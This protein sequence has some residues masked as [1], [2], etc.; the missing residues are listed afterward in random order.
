M[1]DAWA[2]RLQEIYSSTGQLKIDSALVPATVAVTFSSTPIFDA[3]K[4]NAFQ[5]TLTGDV[6]SSTLSNATAGQFIF[7]TITQD[8]TGGHTFA[9]PSNF[10]NAPTVVSTA[11]KATNVVGFYDGTNFNIAGQWN[12][13][14]SGT[15]GGS[16]TSVGMTGD[17][18]LYQPTVSGSPITTSGTLAPALASADAGYVL[19]GPIGSM[20]SNVSYRQSKVAVAS[21]T[22]GTI[23]FDSPI[24]SGSAIVVVPLATSSGG[25]YFTTISDTL[26]TSYTG[27]GGAAAT[28][29][30][31]GFAA[32]SGT[33]TIT[34]SGG[35]TASGVPILA[36][37]LP[38]AA[39]YVDGS[40]WASSSWNTGGAAPFTITS[41]SVTPT[42][43]TDAFIVIQTSNGTCYPSSGF[44]TSPVASHAATVDSGS[45]ETGAI[46]LYAPGN[47]GSFAFSVTMATHTGSCHNSG[48]TYVLCFTQS[49]SASAAPWV[50]RRL[51]ES[52][53]PVTA[54]SAIQSVNVYN[55]SSNFSLTAGSDNTV[56][57]EAIT[58]PVSGG[59]F[60]VLCQY[61]LFLKAGSSA[62]PWTVW[63]SDGTNVFNGWE[64]ETTDATK[65]S[66]NSSA[67]SPV[68]YTNNQSVTFT[69]HVQMDAGATSTFV[70]ETATVG[71]AKSFLSL[72][73]MQSRN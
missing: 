60:R 28:F 64:M 73:V 17:G 34:V 38:G 58:M 39:T 46:W 21:G 54:I 40:S 23:T 14:T 45:A 71:G 56:F 26:S 37:E 48:T 16:V 3:T 49:A 1:V 25:W 47:T 11:S 67:M 4:G 22:S 63:M 50:A 53:L 66:A 52:D 55:L 18:V 10:Q 42:N 8:G 33:C 68:S 24:Q 5:I 62:M 57:S 65:P 29:R 43:S 51:Q 20:Q 59:P 70:Y 13:A 35:S 19:A 9:W 27:Y 72:S 69:V 41:S 31:I 32:S 36:I 61:G 7:F 44:S 30:A 12:T 15:G 6:T 2:S